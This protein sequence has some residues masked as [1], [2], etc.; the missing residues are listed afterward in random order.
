MTTSNLKWLAHLSGLISSALFAGMGFIG[1]L[2]M[3][4]IY[5]DKDLEV[6]RHAKEALN[7][8]ITIIIYGVIC[9][10]LALLLVGFLLFIVLGIFGLVM[11]IVATVK[12]ANDE[13]YQYPFTIRLLK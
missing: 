11:P 12:A 13:N 10:I 6:A 5:K 9:F 1:P 8:Q 7:F 3:Y 4:L 2:V